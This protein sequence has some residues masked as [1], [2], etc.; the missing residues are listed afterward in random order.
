[1]AKLPK[2]SKSVCEAKYRI[3][4]QF[5][6]DNLEGLGA[7]KTH[8]TIRERGFHNLCRIDTFVKLCGAPA[9]EEQKQRVLNHVEQGFGVA[10]P[11]LYINIDN[12]LAGAVGRCGL[13]GHDGLDRVCAMADTGIEELYVQVI[14][15]GYSLRGLDCISSFFNWL[16]RGIKV[17]QKLIPF[18]INKVL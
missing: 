12:Y 1:M 10:C 11:Q 3:T 6:I 8:R 13:V 15:V 4:D 5:H 2:F 7:T 14:P 17:E 9:S 16:A 18:P